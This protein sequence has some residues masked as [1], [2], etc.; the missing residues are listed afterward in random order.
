M[1]KKQKAIKELDLALKEAKVGC[2]SDRCWEFRNHGVDCPHDVRCDDLWFDFVD[3]WEDQESHVH[4]F[5]RFTNSAPPSEEGNWEEYQ[6]D[7]DIPF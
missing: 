5:V 4:D 6:M 3:G 7:P 1:T 2:N